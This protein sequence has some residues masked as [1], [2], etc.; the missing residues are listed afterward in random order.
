MIE[1]EKAMQILSWTLRD[2]VSFCFET[3]I[4]KLLASV[5]K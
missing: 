5:I 2:R 3:I 1:N 4:I